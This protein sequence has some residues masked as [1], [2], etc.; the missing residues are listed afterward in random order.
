[1]RLSIIVDKSLYLEYKTKGTPEEFQAF[2]DAFLRYFADIVIKRIND[3]VRRKLYNWDPLSDAW[4][5]FKKR[6]HLDPR[7]WYASGQILESIGYKYYPMGDVYVIGVHPTKKHNA[8]MK[9]GINKGKKMK[10]SILNLIRYMEFGTAAMPSR[11]LFVPALKEF[12]SKGVQEK[13]Y[14]KFILEYKGSVIF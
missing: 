8:Y 12:K 5:N 7:T 6:M 13:I 3:I 14:Q 11:P 10:V 2:M 9:G 1:M 4:A